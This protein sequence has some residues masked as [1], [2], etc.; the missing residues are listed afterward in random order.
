MANDPDPPPIP[1]ACTPT[2]VERAYRYARDLAYT[3]VTALVRDG[4]RYPTDVLRDRRAERTPTGDRYV[5]IGWRW[6]PLRALEQA[7]ATGDALLERLIALALSCDRTGFCYVN[8]KWKRRE[9]DPEWPATRALRWGRVWGRLADLANDTNIITEPYG[10]GDADDRPPV[11]RGA[12]RKRL[13][14]Q[15]A[16]VAV[17]L[18]KRGDRSWAEV[19]QALVVDVPRV[20]RPT[21]EGVRRLHK[22]A[23]RMLVTWPSYDPGI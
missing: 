20:R 18:L 7:T 15:A 1:P 4:R 14:H 9:N 12:R 11:P 8:G 19:T 23:T 21:R 3:P 10:S 13:E 2:D 16:A 17:Y 5:T 22:I 6:A